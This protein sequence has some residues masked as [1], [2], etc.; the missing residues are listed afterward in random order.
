[1]NRFLILDNHRSLSVATLNGNFQHPTCT[2]PSL[3]TAHTIGYSLPVVLNPIVSLLSSYWTWF[4]QSQTCDYK[5]PPY[6][7]SLKQTGTVVTKSLNQEI[8]APQC[9]S[10]NVQRHT[11]NDKLSGCRY[12]TIKVYNNET[13]RTNRIIVWKYGTCNHQ[14]K[15]TWDFLDHIRQ[16]T[17]EKPYTCEICKK[18][19]AQRGNLIKHR[20][21][22]AKI[23]NAQLVQQNN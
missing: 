11:A 17:G 1:M 21:L 22:H 16:H 8:M 6:D 7:I 12:E 19:F 5:S 13:K 18:H 10:R 14:F 9:N 20:R 3:I 4:P 15:K 2:E 23:D